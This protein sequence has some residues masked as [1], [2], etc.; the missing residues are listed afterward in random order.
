MADLD[1]TQLT[2]VELRS[3]AGRITEELARRD[4]A[5]ADAETGSDK[6]QRQPVMEASADDSSCEVITL[7]SV[8]ERL[9]FAQEHGLM[10]ESGDGDSIEEDMDCFGIPERYARQKPPGWEQYR[11]QK[12]GMTFFPSDHDAVYVISEGAFG[13]VAAR[14]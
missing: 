10:F 5:E 14:R 7:A 9:K 2:A 13:S 11:Q 6:L 3:L 1:L 8:E 12:P 4:V